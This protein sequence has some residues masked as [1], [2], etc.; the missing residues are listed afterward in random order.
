MIFLSTLN[1]STRLMLGF[2][3]A[4]LLGLSIATLGTV[5]MNTLAGQLRMVT[6]DK[7]VKVDLYADIKDHL[8][9]TAGA[10]RNIVISADPASRAAEKARIAESR[11]GN[12]KDMARLDR[13]LVL[14]RGR[15][16][17]KALGDACGPYFDGIDQVIALIEK[18]QAE[19][20]TK[21]LLGDMRQKQQA[22]FKA[23]D[24]SSD[25]Q[26]KLA[27]ELATDSAAEASRDAMLMMALAVLLG[28]VSGLVCWAI[29]HSLTRALGAEPEQLND[30]VR[31]VADG[32]LATPVPVRT[33]DTTSTMAAVQR[34]QA[35]LKHTVS[36]VRGNA[37]SVATGSAQIAQ[38]NTDLSQRTEEQASALQETAATMDQ[39][40]ST[41]RN[42]ADNAKQANQLAIGASTVAA[43]GGDVVGQVVETMKG[44]NDSSRKIADIISVIDGIA[45]QTN[46]L[47]LNA[48]VEAARAGEQGRGFA[49]VASEV[50]NL[51]QRSAEAAKEIK[52]LITASV[53]RV[54]QGTSLVD[55][56]GHTMEEI[57]ASIKRVTD[58]V[59]EI[60][61]A[62]SEQ[63]SGVNQVG[64]AVT[65]MDQVTQQNA[66]LV[67]ESAAAAESLKTQAHQLLQAMAVFRLGEDEPRIAPA[68]AARA[69]TR[70]ERRSPGRATNVMRPQFGAKAAPAARTEPVLA[71]PP[72]P[73][74]TQPKTG[75][76]DWESF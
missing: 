19:D 15:E 23:V 10:V 13:M 25:F 42:N 45:F 4:C 32:D 66:A 48:A 61:A 29:T 58:I 16:L 57:V 76:D 30:A 31:R 2:G 46:I 63:S 51:A 11:A 43:K 38:G 21:L 7:M 59:S 8:N 65:Q 5:Q 50:R 54:E 47:A 18:G 49:V 37:E 1:V 6:E 14:P 55:Q 62:S 36:T 28:V 56:A 17:F 69:A 53:E 26:H 75:T 41:V 22:V 3:L 74:A 33:G 72:Q 73:Q 24:E 12:T 52:S 39:L 20:A 35:S 27:Q 40:G 71:T 64:Q 34:M 70:T 9:V 68:M 60:S 44:I 67:E